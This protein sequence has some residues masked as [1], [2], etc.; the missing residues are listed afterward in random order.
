M[1]S[2]TVQASEFNLNKKVSVHK[3]WQLNKFCRLLKDHDRCLT[4]SII[5]LKSNTATRGNNGWNNGKKENLMTINRLVPLF[6]QIGHDRRVLASNIIKKHYLES[7][8]SPYTYLGR[9]RFNRS[10]YA[11]CPEE[12]YDEIDDMVYYDAE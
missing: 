12:H 1:I 6:L 10:F 7:Y 2:Y 3:K 8:W 9:R 11:L 5:A 4:R